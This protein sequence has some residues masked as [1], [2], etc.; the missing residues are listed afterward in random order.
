MAEALRT[1][2]ESDLSELA[3]LEPPKGF[4]RN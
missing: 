2:A 1:I 3:T 4:G